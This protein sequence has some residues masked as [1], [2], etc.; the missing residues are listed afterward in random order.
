MSE[1]PDWTVW[2]LAA[3]VLALFAWFFRHVAIGIWRY[4]RALVGMIQNWPQIRR[5]MTEA[6]VRSGGR[7]PLW[8]RAVRVSLLVALTGLVLF[9]VWRR[10]G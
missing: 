8:F 6:E 5:A 7:Y 9:L 3:A 4:G 10:F 2:P 1:M